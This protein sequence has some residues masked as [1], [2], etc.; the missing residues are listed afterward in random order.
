MNNIQQRSR[1]AF[2]TAFWGAVAALGL[3]FAAD[4][5]RITR[6]ESPVPADE[7]NTMRSDWVRIGKDFGHVIAREET[8]AKH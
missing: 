7:Q 6:V 5:P 8:A 4:S 1:K 3:L 2:W